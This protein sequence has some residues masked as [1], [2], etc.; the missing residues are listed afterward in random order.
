MSSFPL[1]CCP[2]PGPSTRDRRRGDIPP[3]KKTRETPGRRP[4]P[5]T[6]PTQ[7]IAGLPRLN[8]RPASRLRTARPLCP[9]EL[10]LL[11]RQPPHDCGH[12]AHNH[13]VT[14]SLVD[15]AID[16]SISAGFLERIINRGPVACIPVERE[17]EDRSHFGPPFHHS[18]DRLGL[19]VGRVALVRVQVQ[20]PDRCT[21][22]HDQA[23]Q[24]CH[25]QAFA[26]HPDLLVL[27]AH[28]KAKRNAHFP[29]L[30]AR[31]PAEK[32]CRRSPRPCGLASA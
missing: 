10:L 11:D 20:R 2:M 32:R 21:T 6:A 22:G 24:P 12:R 28:A 27:G 5:R 15:D 7:T 4:E 19:W 30:I 23:D 14:D 31:A 1:T 26:E 17:V 8:Q 18:H 16:E 25:Q 9:P 13:P 29:A 3:C